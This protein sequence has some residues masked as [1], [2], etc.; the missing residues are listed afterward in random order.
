[1]HKSS[2][3]CTSAGHALRIRYNSKMTAASD[4][5]A[6]QGI[7][8]IPLVFESLGGWDQQAIQELKK[9]SSALARHSGEEE[10]DTWRKMICRMSIILMKGNASL[11]SGRLPTSPDDFFEQGII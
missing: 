9:L 4:A 10:S 11:L 5:C 2:A 8:F 1:M 6:A 7:K 3:L